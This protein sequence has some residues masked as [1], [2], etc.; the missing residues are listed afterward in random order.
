MDVRDNEI[1]FIFNS[2]LYDDNKARGYITSLHKHKIKEHDLFNESLTERQIAEIAQ[3][4]NIPVEGLLD[5]QSATY[6]EKFSGTE[7]K[8]HDLLKVLKEN[9]DVMKTPLVIMEHKAVVIDDPYTFVKDDMD[10]G[11]VQRGYKS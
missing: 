9:P 5:R 3:R 10:M 1:L 6:R 8:G 2:K 7:L 11:G 4:M